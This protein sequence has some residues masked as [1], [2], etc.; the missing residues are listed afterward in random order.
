MTSPRLSVI[1]PIYNAA[2]TLQACLDSILAQWS[3]DRELILIDDGSKDT[4]WDICCRYAAAH[5]ATVRAVHQENAGVSAARNRGIAVSR[6]TYITF[7]D[8]DDRVAPDQ[9]ARM[10]RAASEQD[11][12][13][14]VCGYYIENGTQCCARSFPY[15][16]GLYTGELLDAIAVESIASWEDKGLPPYSCIRLIRRSVL[17]EHG[18]RFDET[19]R[20]SEDYHFWV[21]VN[22]CICRLYL[23]SD[24]YLYYYIM[25]SQSA[26]HRHIDGYW[27]G[28]R[29][30]YESFARTLPDTP[31]IRQREKDMLVQRS[32][33]A[34]SNACF[35]ADAHAASAEMKDILSD[36]ALVSAAGE[37]VGQSRLRR[38]PQYRVYTR[39]LHWG[40]T[41]PVRMFYLFRQRKLHRRKKPTQKEMTK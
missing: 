18:L 33:T 3:D 37:L 11:A 4:S 22:F 32:V 1:V 35:L 36:E 29:R 39:L 7:A 27:G 34:L 6:G 13:M 23:M 40:L 25:N 30:M 20:R 12:D 26:T 16:R 41:V 2:D 38:Y 10:L 15:P 14:V 5:P 28:V 8:A 19:L 17:T 21:R 24:A 9:Y 31:Q